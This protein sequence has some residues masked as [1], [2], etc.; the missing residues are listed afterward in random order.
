MET[1]YVMGLDL[2]PPGEPTG[3]AILECSDL[4]PQ[5]PQ[6]RLRYLERFPPPT[7]Y[8]RIVDQVASR[9]ATPDLDDA[10]MIVD[11]T[12]VGQIV[13]DQL[14]RAQPRRAVIAVFINAGYSVQRAGGVGWLVPKKDLVSALQMVL[15]TRRLKVAPDLPDAGL[16][17]TELANFRLRRVP[18]GDAANIEWR[19]GRHDDL[20]L[21]VALTCWYAERFGTSRS[22]PFVE[23][24][25]LVWPD[26]DYFVG[27]DGELDLW[28][29]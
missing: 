10:P 17:A 25:L 29:D 8:H 5:Q 21:A 20:V 18:V 23:G 19:E 1:S 2:G 3:F 16:L 15:Q 12:A 26:A 14:R 28:P 13:L 6:Y 27:P 11:G 4:S 7:P 24:P 9:A 22:G